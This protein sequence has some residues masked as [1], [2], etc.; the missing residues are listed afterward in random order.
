MNV[1][2]IKITPHHPEM[3]VA[4]PWPASMAHGAPRLG[5]VAAIDAPIKARQGYVVRVPCGLSVELPAGVAA[6]INTHRSIETHYGIS[7][8]G[9]PVRLD[10]RHCGSIEVC[11]AIDPSWMSHMLIHPGRQVAQLV[12]DAS[13]VH[14]QIQKQEG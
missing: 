5:L 11:A 6:W 3:G 10:C 4:F 9:S 13:V 2:T 12:I 14:W 1:P 8:V 7:V